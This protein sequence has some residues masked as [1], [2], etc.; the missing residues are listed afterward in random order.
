MESKGT[1]FEI[2]SVFKCAWLGIVLTC[3]YCCIVSLHQ[4]SCNIPP[5]NSF[6]KYV[7]SMVFEWYPFTTSL[8]ICL[9]IIFHIYSYPYYVLF[10]Y[11]NIKSRG[12]GR[13]V[14]L[15]SPPP[16]GCGTFYEYVRMHGWLWPTSQWIRKRIKNYKYP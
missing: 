16:F 4:W 1:L 10:Y 13:N 9:I 12:G 7:Y 5:Q 6:K 15:T 8:F 2:L 3:F 14:L 11:Q